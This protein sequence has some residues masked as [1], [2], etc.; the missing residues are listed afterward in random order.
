MAFLKLKCASA[1]ASAKGILSLKEKISK[2]SAKKEGMR[3]LKRSMTN[4]RFVTVSKKKFNERQKM[5]LRMT[6]STI[7]RPNMRRMTQMSF[8]ENPKREK[9]NI[10]AM[11]GYDDR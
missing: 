4:M 10:E 9:I 5:R 7:Y 1:F 8:K 11:F 3:K 2:V 6:K